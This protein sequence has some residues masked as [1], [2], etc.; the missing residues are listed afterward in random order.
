MQGE[1][2]TAVF[3]HPRAWIDTF[4][5][6]RRRLLSGFKIKSGNLKIGLSTN[7]NKLCG[8]IH[9]TIVDG[10][11]A[12]L[13]CALTTRLN[14]TRLYLDRFPANWAKVKHEYDLGA[15]CSLYKTVHFFG[16]SSYSALT[17]NFEAK[18]IARAYHELR[19]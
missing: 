18:D 9:D 19:R 11:C 7:F 16:I 3:S 10:T 17:P 1:M 15:V 4:H 5:Q 2:G 14:Y 12:T 13:A 6:L 8:C